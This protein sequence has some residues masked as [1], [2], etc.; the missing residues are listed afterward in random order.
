MHPGYRTRYTGLVIR[1]IIIVS[2][3]ADPLPQTSASSRA[4]CSMRKLRWNG[5]GEFWSLN[6]T[7]CINR[8]ELRKTTAKLEMFETLQDLIQGIDRGKLMIP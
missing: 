1:H 8:D 5:I 7:V 2:T 3:E 6:H 4:L